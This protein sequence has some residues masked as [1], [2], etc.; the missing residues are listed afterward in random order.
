MNPVA[1]KWSARAHLDAGT[2]GYTGDEFNPRCFAAGA[3]EPGPA[4]HM[5]KNYYQILRIKNDATAEQIGQ[6]YYRACDRVTQ[7][8]VK[9]PETLALLNE[10]YESL[11]DPNSRA[12]Y[13]QSLLEPP[14]PPPRLRAAPPPQA[15]F[16]MEADENQET[17]HSG[18]NKR[19]IGIAI[20][21]GVALLTVLIGFMSMGKPRAPTAS[22]AAKDVTGTSTI[23]VSSEPLASG[24]PPVPASSQGTTSTA[25]RT[26]DQVFADVANSIV[27]IV[28]MDESHNTLAGGSGVVTAR[29]TVITN[30]HVALKGPILEVRAGKDGFPATVT[31]ADETYDLC[32][33]NV[34]GGFNAPSVDIGNMQYVRTGQ[35]VFAV[36][37]PQGLDLTISEGI[38]S[39]LRETG[40]GRIIQTTAP[41][42]PGSSGGGLFNISGQLIG[43]TTFQ[44]RTGQNLNFAVPADW[45]TEM[46]TRGGPGPSLQ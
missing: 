5:Q 24:Q 18:T 44:L 2:L 12:T 15:D 9:D 29:A 1:A 27:R 23:P 21:I 8:G 39:S 14:P 42:S 46:V 6:A 11:I 19:W 28:V 33:L 35:K 32:Q 34:A 13:D 25:P 43:I 10:A 45:I 31:L 22:M 20:A 38:V 17:N 7:S 4:P 36:G 41:I 37:A 30:C 3:L 16:S 40:L 26:G